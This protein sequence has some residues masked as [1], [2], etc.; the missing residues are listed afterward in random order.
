MPDKPKWHTVR[1]PHERP[2][3][4]APQ[5]ELDDAAGSVPGWTLRFWL[6][7]LGLLLL[8]ALL[9]WGAW[10]LRALL[11]V[12]IILAV[13]ALAAL[14]STVAALFQAATVTLAALVSAR[15]RPPEDSP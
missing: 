12:A 11:P 5:P 13:M 7:G 10:K 1:E 15:Q 14:T 8:T 2:A 9:A 3:F 6:R 4:D